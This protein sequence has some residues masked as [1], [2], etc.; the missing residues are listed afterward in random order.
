MIRLRLPN[1]LSGEGGVGALLSQSSLEHAWR[2]IATAQ[3]KR[4][5]YT[6]QVL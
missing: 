6:D 4:S 3:V 1:P 5:P 2:P